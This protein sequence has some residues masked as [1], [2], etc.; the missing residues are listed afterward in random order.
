MDDQGTSLGLG[1]V[2]YRFDNC[3]DYIKLQS[4][5]LRNLNILKDR[6]HAFL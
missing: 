2:I 1:L 6:Q 5:I 4:L 3:R